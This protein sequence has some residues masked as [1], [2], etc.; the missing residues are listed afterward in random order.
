MGVQE[1]KKAATGTYQGSSQ[2]KNS[3]AHATKNYAGTY[4][5]K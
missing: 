3:L 5:A 4:E 2:L 1:G